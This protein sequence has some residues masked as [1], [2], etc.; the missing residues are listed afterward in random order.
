MFLL[1]LMVSIVIV[2]VSGFMNV[3]KLVTGFQRRP[4]SNG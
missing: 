4:D 1:L 2:Y 3:D